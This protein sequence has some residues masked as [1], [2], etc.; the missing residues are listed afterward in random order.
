M[1]RKRVILFPFIMIFFVVFSFICFAEERSGENVVKP[2][3]DITM[4]AQYTGI[5]I[6]QGENIDIDLVFE[7][8]GKRGEDVIVWLDKAPQGWETTITSYGLEVTGLY[9][10]ADK[11]KTLTFKSIPPPD[12][13][14]GKYLFRIGAKTEDGK[15]RMQEDVS[16]EV[17]KKGKEVKSSNKIELSTFYPVLKGPVKGEFKFSVSVK[18][19]LDREAVFNLFGSGPEGWNISFKPSYESTYISSLRLQPD[20]T[21]NIDVE[22]KPPLSAETGE[23]LFNVRVS[24]E[25]AE[26]EA[27][28]KVI[29]IGSYEL[30]VG[31]SS[32]LLSLDAKPGE[33]SNVSIYVKNTGT[34]E[35]KDITFTTF[36]PENWK[37][38]FEP[39]RIDFIKPNEFKQ[40][41][42]IITPYEEALVGDYS[43]EL[44]A[45]GEEGSQDSVEFRV[46][47]KATP[48][49]G[50]AGIGIIAFVIGGLVL[51]FRFLG[52]R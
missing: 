16:V 20:Q 51:T 41:E 24:T 5:K 1:K 32:G 45:K 52:R 46:T 27:E 15:I 43:V 19:K 22:V 47:V 38:E 28:L 2:E 29:L 7:N 37:V 23:Y 30:K 40:V 3:R 48:I 12:V 13:K 44:T 17:G 9:V 31:T 26:A 21:K 10:G 49:W 34:A 25:G 35:N 8:H 11:E 42:V 39:E 33:K 50:W 18:S 36:K 14:P 4:N 6:L